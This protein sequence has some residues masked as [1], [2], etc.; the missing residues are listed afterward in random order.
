MTFEQLVD[1]AAAVVYARVADVRGQ[2][3][4]DRQSIDSII[5]LEALQYMK[6]RSRSFSCHAACLGARRVA[7]S[8]CCLARRRC[9]RAISWCCSS[10]RVDRHSHS[11]GIRAR[12]LPRRPRGRQWTDAGD[13]TAAEGERCRATGS[14][15]G[16]ATRAE[17]DQLCRHCSVDGAAM[18]LLAA[19]MTVIVIVGAASPAQ[20]YLKLGV[21]VGADIVDVRWRRPIPYFVNDRSIADVTASQLRD[22]VGRAFAT[23]QGV[24]TATIQS[25]FQGF[26]TALPG[27]QDERTT[28]GFLDRPDLDRVLGLTSFILDP[29]TGGDSRG[30]RV[31]QH[32]LQLVCGSRRRARPPGS[33]IDRSA[34]DRASSRTWALGAR[35]DG[36]V[37][38]RAAGHRLGGGHVSHR[39]GARSDCGPRAAS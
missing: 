26:T 33:R 23:W 7:S 29:A 35:R 18:R 38:D 15:R 12:D 16:G 39:V 34:R 14:R 4:A 11:A 27:M 1:E 31:L 32:S 25:Q 8:T 36:N 9:V 20:A 13:S 6:G 2:W 10:R 21:R 30:G 17:P 22:A 5:T 19:L 24:R 37:R 3:T 28:F